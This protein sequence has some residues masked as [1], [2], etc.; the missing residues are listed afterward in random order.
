MSIH[1]YNVKELKIILQSQKFA[2]LKFSASW[3]G[4][5]RVIA[6]YVETLAKKYPS[7]CF[8]SIDVDESPDIAQMYNVTAMPT[9][10]SLVSGIPLSTHSG[11]DKDLLQ[12]MI[13]SLQLYQS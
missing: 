11:A 4:P 9:F 2:I 6:P 5:C 10:I 7:I 8:L 1:V 3:C 13:S 12:K